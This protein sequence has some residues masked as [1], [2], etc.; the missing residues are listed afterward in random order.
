ML[1]SVQR[2]GGPG[3]MAFVTQ[4]G[5]GQAQVSFQNS[6]HVDITAR[7]ILYS[8]YR[9]APAK[10]ENPYTQRIRVTRPHYV[11]A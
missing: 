9:K 5:G 7:R 6:A 10:Y 2:R 4:P 3:E 1:A 11:N 8:L